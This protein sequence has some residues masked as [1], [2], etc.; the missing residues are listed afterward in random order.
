MIIDCDEC[1]AKVDAEEIARIDYFDNFNTLQGK[2]IFL[3]CPSCK[4]GLLAIEPEGDAT[5]GWGPPE[6]IYPP[7]RYIHYKIP[8]TLRRSFREALI[9]LQSSCYLAT[10]IMCRRTLE[11]LCHHHDSSFRDLAAGLKKLSD[12]K[13]IDSR[14]LEWGEALRQ[15]GNLAAHDPNAEIN[16]H[17]A[18]DLVD[19]TEA[20]LN[21]VFVL[22]DQFEKFKERRAQRAVTIKKEKGA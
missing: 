4:G 22:H 19:F 10:V 14:L 5:R 2:T 3:R 7:Q 15:D 12:N 11:G 9:C 16:W 21:H 1:E 8:D 20:I 13:I 17:D 6:R 18:S